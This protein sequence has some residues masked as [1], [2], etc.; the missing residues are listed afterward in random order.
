M[1]LKDKTFAQINSY[2][3]GIA[4]DRGNYQEAMYF[5]AVAIVYNPKLRFSKQ[6][7][8]LNVAILMLRWFGPQAYDRV[9]NLTR[10][11]RRRRS[12]L[13]T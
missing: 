13:A 11:L 5:R 10:T 2:I 7:L 6:D 4:I 8:R 1:S 12:S 9:R 3:A